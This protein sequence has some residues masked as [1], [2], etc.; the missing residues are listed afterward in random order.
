MW[1]RLVVDQ[2]KII[3]P[4]IEDVLDLWVELHGWQWSAISRELLVNLRQVVDV[5]M[6]VCKRMNKRARAIAGDLGDHHG[7]QGVGGDVEGDAEEEVGGALVEL[8]VE[9]VC[10]AIGGALDIEL[11]QA[12]A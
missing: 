6:R 9:E 1:V 10:A 4:E 3:D 7:E 12:M 11:E 5:D 8:A 2:L